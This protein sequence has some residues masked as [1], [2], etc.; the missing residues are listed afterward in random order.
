MLMACRSFSP[1]DVIDM[2]ILPLPQEIKPR[3]I[4]LLT[5][6]RIMHEAAALLQMQ[7]LLAAG[8]FA[9]FSNQLRLAPEEMHKTDVMHPP[10]KG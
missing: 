5:G 6:I 1:D 9:S 7:L 2:G 4:D 3:S 10:R 8:D